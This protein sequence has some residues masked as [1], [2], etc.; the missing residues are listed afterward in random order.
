VPQTALQP[1]PAPG[2]TAPWQPRRTR[3]GGARCPS[4]GP[5]RETAR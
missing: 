4:R 3:P 5:R 2:P 1:P